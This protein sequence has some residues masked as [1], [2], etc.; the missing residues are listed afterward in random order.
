M[1]LTEL[2]LSTLAGL[3]ITLGALLSIFIRRP[4]PRLMSLVTVQLGS[5]SDTDSHGFNGFSRLFSAKRRRSAHTE[6]CLSVQSVFIR[7]L[8]RTT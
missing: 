1:N 3:S 2:L 6:P 5:Q 7:V 4:G 8:F